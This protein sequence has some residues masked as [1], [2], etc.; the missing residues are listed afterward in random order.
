VIKKNFSDFGKFKL[1]GREHLNDLVFKKDCY[2]NLLLEK[3]SSQFKI[4]IEDLSYYDAS[5]VP[6]L[7]EVQRIAPAEVGE[8]KLA[9]LSKGRD[10]E[11]INVFGK[12]AQQV[13]RKFF[14]EGEQKDWVK[15]Q[16]ANKGRVRARAKV[17]RYDLS[18]FDEVNKMIDGMERG[19]V[20]VAETTAPEII[21]ACK[22]A[23]AIVTNQGGMMSHAAIVSRELG[24]PC[25]VGTGDATHVIKDGDQVEVDA[26]K[27]VVR[28]IKK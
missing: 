22:K 10:G 28:I 3:L 27:G 23:S 11:T 7:F 5:E 9:Y 2:A 17:I 16:V 18:Q 4:P 6:K 13:M 21:L 20:L 19:Q 8:R 14:S 26:D 1:K 25:I 12:R 24:I 15:G